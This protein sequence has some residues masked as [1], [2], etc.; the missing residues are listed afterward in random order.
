MLIGSFSLL[1]EYRNNTKKPE[2]AISTI[3]KF[4]NLQEVLMSKCHAMI[5][6]EHCAVL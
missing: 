4:S 2:K 5:D 6:F 1:T 3:T